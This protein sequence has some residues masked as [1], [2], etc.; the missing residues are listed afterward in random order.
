M[1]PA[2]EPDGWYL[3]ADFW[4]DGDATYDTTENNWKCIAQPDCIIYGRF[5]F[6]VPAAPKLLGPRPLLAR[7]H[8]APPSRD[9]GL[10]EFDPQ[11]LRARIGVRRRSSAH[12]TLH[13]SGG[14]T[15]P[16]PKGAV[17]QTP[18]PLADISRAPPLSEQGDR[19]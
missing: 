17:G 8:P 7:A 4:I 1:A 3:L 5:L 10:L 9:D 14:V 18:V 11:A 12:R 19:R 15:P 16:P 6:S 13:R 2:S